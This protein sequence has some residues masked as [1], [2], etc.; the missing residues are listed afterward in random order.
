MSKTYSELILLPTFLERFEYLKLSGIV[1][2]TTFGSHRYLNQK[3]Y[4][5]DPR[6]L[7][8]RAE[9][10]VRDE[11]NDLGMFG[12]PIGGPIT[13]HHINPVTQEDLLAGRDILFDPENLI[14]VSSMTHKAIHYGNQSL[15][16]LPPVARTP[17]DTCP[18]RR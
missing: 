14:S 9:V 4:T 10:I 15:L 16:M 1:G 17:N 8:A 12:F 5:Q 6:W 3:F 7:K 11:G 13:I 18:W 2:E